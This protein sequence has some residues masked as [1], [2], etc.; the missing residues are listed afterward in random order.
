MKVLVSGGAGYIGSHTTRQL[1]AEG[2][3]VTVLDSLATG[4][5][6]AVDSRARFCRGDI[7]DEA[8]L[9]AV[10]GRG[11]FDAV[12]H[13]AA[14]SLVLE[15][16]ENPLKYYENNV[17]GTGALVKAMAQYGTG[18]IIFSS[19][20]A[21]Y[22]QPKD[23]PITEEEDTS[24]ENPY[25]ETKLAI[26]KLFKWAEPAYG[27]RYVS[28]RYF[29]AA[30]ADATGDIGEDHS[31]ETHLIPLVLQ[32]PLKKRETVSIFGTDYP[33][34]DGT[35][36]RDYIHVTDLAAAHI[37]ALRHLAGRGESGIFNLG[38]GTGFT[39]REVIEEARRIT[40]HAIP[41]IEASRRAGD[42]AT[43]VAS[44]EKARSVLG[45][46]PQHTTLDE[47]IRSAWKWHSTHPEGFAD[48]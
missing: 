30:G 20:A 19:T 25:G 16:V 3:D 39:V 41:V 32:V 14:S 4:H 13:F 28:L 37:L 42:P 45:W 23:I 33:T 46:K 15:S 8:F 21:T 1:I 9:G 10:F 31:P 47:I 44:S 22:G 48:R 43:L 27:I 12:I 34:K 18:K 26:E 11:A 17:G 29:N 7:R 38:S 5:A 2:H 35:C 40:G 36:V 6:A 24:P